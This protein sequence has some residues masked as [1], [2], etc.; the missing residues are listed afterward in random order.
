MNFSDEQAKE[1]GLR[2]VACKHWQWMS[3]MRSTTGAGFRVEISAGDPPQKRALLNECRPDLNDP[4]TKGCL[5]EL[6]R[7]ALPPTHA[8][9]VSSYV[10]QSSERGW[11]V[12]I[13]SFEGKVWGMQGASEADVLVQALEH[14]EREA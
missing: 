12:N 2:A 8:V 5:L 10:I 13:A 11:F 7:N 6:V 9:N 1:L 3:G 4:A 14:A